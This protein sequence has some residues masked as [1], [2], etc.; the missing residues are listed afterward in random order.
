MKGKMTNI[1]LLI[2]VCIIVILFFSFTGFSYGQDKIKVLT[3][4]RVSDRIT[5]KVLDDIYYKD[6]NREE[7]EE[8]VPV[9]RDD[10]FWPDLLADDGIYSNFKET[11]KFLSPETVELKKAVIQLII[12]AEKSSLHEFYLIPVFAKSEYSFVPSEILFAE[13]KDQKL[14]EWIDKYLFKFRITKEDLASAHYP[15][16]VP[17]PPSFPKADPPVGFNYLANKQMLESGVGGQTITTNTLNQGMF[18]G[19]FFPPGQG[20]PLFQGVPPRGMG[21]GGRGG[22]GG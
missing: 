20:I 6:V 10:G 16:Y 2:I 17:R 12:G 11:N 21:P 13:A 5:G 7:L 4:E 14:L 8:T 3:G 22:G 15:M 18:P 19:Q 1:E 9:P